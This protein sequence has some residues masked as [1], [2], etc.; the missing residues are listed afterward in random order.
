[1]SPKLRNFLIITLFVLSYTTMIGQDRIPPPPNRTGSPPPFG[2]PMPIGENIY[3]L[4]FSG[5]ALGV[6]F[7]YNKRKQKVTQ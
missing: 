4:V 5:V 7:F 2:L 6:Y 3:V 1:M